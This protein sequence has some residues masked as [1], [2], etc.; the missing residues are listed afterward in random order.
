VEPV[1]AL[2][3]EAPQD[4]EGQVLK[5]AGAAVEELEEIELRAFGAAAS[6]VAEGPEGADRGILETEPGSPGP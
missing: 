6:V 4:R 5:G 3:Q 1:Q 2:P